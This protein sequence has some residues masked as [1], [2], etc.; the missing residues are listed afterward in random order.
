[1]IN[2]KK[3]KMQVH[4]CKEGKVKCIT[5]IVCH[6]NWQLGIHQCYSRRNAHLQEIEG[7]APNSGR[8][9]CPLT[10]CP[11][12]DTSHHG[13]RFILK[14][15]SGLPTHFRPGRGRH[16][17]PNYCSWPGITSKRGRVFEGASP[18][19][20]SGWSVVHCLL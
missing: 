3:G 8:S 17:K 14:P 9:A 15:K 13:K 1:M 20:L 5:A 7:P 2:M 10:L 19:P 12:P 6:Y 16:V 11:S 18:E 4:L